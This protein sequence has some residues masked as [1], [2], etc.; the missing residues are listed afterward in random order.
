MLHFDVVRPVPS[1]EAEGNAHM[2]VVQ[3]QSS[4]ISSGTELKIYTGEFDD[5]S[6]LDETIEG[7]K[8]EVMSYPMESVQRRVNRV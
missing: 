7:L 3:S 4:M 2:V 5:G 6:A 8:D 1:L